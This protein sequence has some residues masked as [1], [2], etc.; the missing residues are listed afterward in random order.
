[1]DTT[2]LDDEKAS[3]AAA[4]VVHQLAADTG[5]PRKLSEVGVSEDVIETL[6]KDALVQADLPG[7]PRRASLEDLIDL[8]RK[9]L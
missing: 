6:A 3:L 8:Y 9:A 4:A 1:V 2:G 5:V 7:N